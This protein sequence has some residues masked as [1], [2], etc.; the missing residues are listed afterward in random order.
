VLVNL[1]RNACDA[2]GG[3]DAPE[4]RIASRREDAQTVIVSVS[5][6]GAGFA[7]PEGERF[8]PF[9]TTKASGL[10]LGLSISRTII[11]AH[12]GRIW[13]DDA[14]GPGSGAMVSFTLPAA[15]H[16]QEPDRAEAAA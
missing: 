6:N 1:V 9:A 16:Q 8:S 4:I 14:D 13:I 7:Q 12:G 5:D 3:G 2:T 10:G 15:R 11:E